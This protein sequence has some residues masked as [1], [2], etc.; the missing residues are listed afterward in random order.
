MEITAVVLL[1]RACSYDNVLLVSSETRTNNGQ[2]NE[3]D[4]RGSR[5]LSVCITE[6]VPVF[7]KDN[8]DDYK[9]GYANGERDEKTNQQ[10]KILEHQLGAA[11]PVAND[12]RARP[13][14][15]QCAPRKQA[16]GSGRR[17]RVAITKPQSAVETP[18]S[19]REKTTRHVQQH[20]QPVIPYGGHGCSR[21]TLWPARST[22]LHQ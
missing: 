11:T 20:P 18:S 15:M 14:T 12:E 1:Y 10:N 13:E 8:A 4:Q 7:G 19:H 6:Q 9:H 2:T 16:H 3:S 5:R 22:M 17:P 21:R